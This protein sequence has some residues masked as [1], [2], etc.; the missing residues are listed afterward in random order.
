VKELFFKN[1]RLKRV[2]KT[3]PLLE[4]N[5]RYTPKLIEH[6]LIPFIVLGRKLLMFLLK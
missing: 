3:E 1:I 2:F 6:A 4:S 5:K